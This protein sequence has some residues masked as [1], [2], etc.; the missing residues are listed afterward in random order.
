VSSPW[1]IGGFSTDAARQCA[2]YLVFNVDKLNMA[3]IDNVVNQLQFHIIGR[4]KEAP[5]WPGVVWG[6]G[7]REAYSNDAVADI[8]DRLIKRSLIDTTP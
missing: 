6:Y 7:E 1:E 2:L 5:C 8:R 3:A 4:G